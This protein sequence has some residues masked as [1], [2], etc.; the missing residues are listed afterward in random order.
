MLLKAGQQSFAASP[1][2]KGSLRTDSSAVKVRVPSGRTLGSYRVDRNFIY[3]D[4]PEIQKPEA[5]FWKWVKEQLQKLLRT[6]V[7][8][9][10]FKNMNY[11][12][13]GIAALIV[14]LVLRKLHLGGVIAK[15]DKTARAFPGEQEDDQNIDPDLM[16]SEAIRNKDYRTAVRYYYIRSLSQ[17]AGKEMIEWH[18]NKTNS[19][20]IKE[21]KAP[22]I[23]KPFERLTILFEKACYGAAALEEAH[24]EEARNSFETFYQA[25]EEL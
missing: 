8:G 14:I 15:R 3:D 4:R 23:K 2:L 1:A 9:Y 11:V 25:V 5:S 6:R 22:E 16:I 7:M 18:V 12:I 17:L 21:L 24:F 19:Q 20:Y 13:I 10:V